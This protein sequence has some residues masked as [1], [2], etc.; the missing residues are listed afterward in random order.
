[1]GSTPLTLRCSKCRKYRQWDWSKDNY[2]KLSDKNLVATG[3][4]RKARR[5]TN[6]RRTLENLAVEVKHDGPSPHTRQYCGHVFW[7]VHP[8]A[9]RLWRAIGMQPPKEKP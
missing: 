5:G 7:S 2:D 4:A 3:G 9:V 8:Q 6:G 1:M